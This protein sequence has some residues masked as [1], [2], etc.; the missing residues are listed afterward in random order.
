MSQDFDAAE[1]RARL[2][3]SDL[4]AAASQVIAWHSMRSE[5]V[6]DDVD[7][8]V[9]SRRI[10]SYAPYWR[11]DDALDDVDVVSRA[12]AEIGSISATLS[13]SAAGP[14]EKAVA[15]EAEAIGRLKV[16]ADE[17]ERRAVA[18]RR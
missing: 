9:L 5:D 15:A 6:R 16:L 18:L 17:C 8:A 10:T 13:A 3:A 11:L 4:Q 1:E 14:G 7:A 12:R 2:A